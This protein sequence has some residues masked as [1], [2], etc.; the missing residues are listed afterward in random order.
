[1]TLKFIGFELVISEEQIYDLTNWIISLGVI[2]SLLFFLLLSNE[3]DRLDLLFL[4]VVLLLSLLF[5]PFSSRVRF[6]VPHLAIKIL[7]AWPAR[8]ELG[9]T[10][11]PKGCWA[12]AQHLNLSMLLYFIGCSVGWLFSVWFDFYN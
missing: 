2:V 1:M 8:L 3:L 10:H 5:W 6:G 11:E 12:W 7:G 4:H 9:S